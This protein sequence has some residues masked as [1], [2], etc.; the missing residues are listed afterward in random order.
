MTSLKNKQDLLKFL[1][2]QEV[3]ERYLKDTNDKSFSVD[4]KKTLSLVE[5]GGAFIY[6]GVGV[7]KTQLVVDILSELANSKK[8]TVTRI[9][10]LPGEHI[11]KP[12]ESQIFD[13][14]LFRFMNVPRL[15]ISIRSLFSGNLSLDQY[16]E[17]LSKF[18]YLILDDLGVEK[19]SDWVL[20]T[21]YVIINERYEKNRK[22]IITSNKDLSEIAKSLGDRIASRIGE[23][24]EIIKLVGDDKR[25]T[26]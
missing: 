14:Y 2:D 20:E 25:L 17:Q 16:L 24:C 5:N 18:E 12:I 9:E 3:P 23:L 7:G 21:L 13:P 6:G 1:S 26:K 15:L 4:F 22:L 8:K 19:P 10:V 11:A